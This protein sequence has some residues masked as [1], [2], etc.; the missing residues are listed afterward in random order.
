MSVT[1][2]AGGRADRIVVVARSAP[3]SSVDRDGA[4]GWSTTWRYA[5]A[6]VMPLADAR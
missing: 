3:R 5:A 4:D 2:V 1:R 6:I